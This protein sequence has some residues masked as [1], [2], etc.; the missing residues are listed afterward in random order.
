MTTHI[1]NS[2]D[3]ADVKTTGQVLNHF[4]NMNIVISFE[5]FLVPFKTKQC[6]H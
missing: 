4:E 5:L 2:F 1:N 3:K 6:L